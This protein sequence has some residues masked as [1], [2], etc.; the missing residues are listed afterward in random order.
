ML[1]CPILPGLMPQ[2]KNK[3]FKENRVLKRRTPGFLK[4]TQLFVVVK[5]LFSWPR[6]GVG[7]GVG[8]GRVE[9]ITTC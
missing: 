3:S 6:I 5:G 7:V 8:G 1:T 9:V 2:D 4:H